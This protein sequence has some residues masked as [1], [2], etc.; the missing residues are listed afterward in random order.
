MVVPLFFPA[1]LIELVAGP[2]RQRTT[3]GKSPPPD[4]DPLATP[5]LAKISPARQAGNVRCGLT[6]I[7]RHGEHR[8]ITEI[9]DSSA[10]TTKRL[11]SSPRASAIQIVRPHDKWFLSV[12][13][14]DNEQVLRKL[15][16]FGSYVN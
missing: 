1:E 11:P 10:C 4:S 5:S 13:F 9:P 3:A 8:D 14:P 12:N 16:D 2:D 7:I 15:N 6:G